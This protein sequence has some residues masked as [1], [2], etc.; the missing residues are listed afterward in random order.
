M[1]PLPSAY[2]ILFHFRFFAIFFADARYATPLIRPD[3]LITLRRYAAAAASPPMMLMP[4]FDA[5][6]PL[7]LMPP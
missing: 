4:R 6:L 1:L 5:A 7:C 3:Y 2:F